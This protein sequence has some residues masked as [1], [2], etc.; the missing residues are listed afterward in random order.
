MRERIATLRREVDRL[1]VKMKEDLGNLKH[2]YVSLPFLCEPCHRAQSRIQMELDTR[3]NESKAELK[4][5]SMSIEVFIIHY[6]SLFHPL[7][8][9]PGSTRQVYRRDR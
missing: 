9:L 2:E 8:S 4:Q 3:K 1:D 6:A 7:S 5:K